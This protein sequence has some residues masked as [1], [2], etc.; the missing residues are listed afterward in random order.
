MWLYLRWAEGGI[1]AHCN[2]LWHESGL[3]FLLK[4][5]IDFC[6]ADIDDYKVRN[7]TDAGARRRDDE[8]GRRELGVQVELLMV[9]DSEADARFGPVVK[10]CCSAMAVL[11]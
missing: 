4:L 7:G 11:S 2:V 1:C 10:H 6:G 5:R 8:I 3:A 9:L